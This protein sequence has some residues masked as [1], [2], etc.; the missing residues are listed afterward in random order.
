MSLQVPTAE[1]L[2]VGTGN[3]LIG[4]DRGHPR[5]LCCPADWFLKVDLLALS[6]IPANHNLLG[7]FQGCESPTQLH[8]ILAHRIFGYLLF[9][10]P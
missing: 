2:A 8:D 3:L 9:F 7:F 6:R 1:R 4:P 10:N 5:W